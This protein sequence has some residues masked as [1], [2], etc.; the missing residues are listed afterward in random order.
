MDNVNDKD[1]KELVR[2]SLID[3]IKKINLKVGV[4]D[5]TTPMA[6]KMHTELL[7]ERKKLIKNLENYK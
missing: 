6:K 7:T 4:F 1:D 2:T 3:G 5:L